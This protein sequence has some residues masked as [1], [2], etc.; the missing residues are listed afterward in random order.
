[1]TYLTEFPDFAATIDTD[2]L[3]AHGLVD[4]SSRNDEIPSFAKAVGDYRIVVWVA[5]PEYVQTGDAYYYVQAVTA[6]GVTIANRPA[7]TLDEALDLVDR[8]TRRVESGITYVLQH[9]T[10]GDWGDMPTFPV[11]LDEDDADEVLSN[12][13]DT[14]SH[15]AHYRGEHA[16]INPH[17]YR[18]LERV[19]A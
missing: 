14:L 18:V 17:N 7:Y 4:G 11:Y 19:T 16:D 12:W 1:M 8:L 6:D 5:Y 3:A 13:I 9:W 15:D 10:D 2:R